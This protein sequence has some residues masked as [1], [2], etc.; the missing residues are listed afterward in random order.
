MNKITIVFSVMF[1]GFIIISAFTTGNEPD[2]EWS[3]WDVS[4]S[5]GYVNSNLTIEQRMVVYSD[6]IYIMMNKNELLLKEIKKKL[7]DK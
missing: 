3:P 7:N 2:D 1:V 4:T 6:S 5:R